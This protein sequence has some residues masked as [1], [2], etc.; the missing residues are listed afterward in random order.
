MRTGEGEKAGLCFELLL[1]YFLDLHNPRVK[2]ECSDNVK[3][4]ISS[5][6]IYFKLLILLDEIAIDFTPLGY[7][8]TVIG[9]SKLDFVLF[10]SHVKLFIALMWINI[11]WTAVDKQGAT[12]K[13]VKKKFAATRKYGKNVLIQENN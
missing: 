11:H 8:N 3:K 9:N 7:I 1:Q 6:T 13:L 12:K 2:N 10:I 5:S 4:N